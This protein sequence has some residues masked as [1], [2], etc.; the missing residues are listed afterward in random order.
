MPTAGTQYN[1]GVRMGMPDNEYQL[2]PNILDLNKRGS[3]CDAK[4]APIF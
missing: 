4:S 2:N 3:G 1:G